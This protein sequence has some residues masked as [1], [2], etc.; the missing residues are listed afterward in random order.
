[1]SALSDRVKDTFPANGDVGV[2]LLSNISVTLSGLDYNTTSLTDGLFVEGP[3]TDQ[4]VGEGLACLLTPENVSQGNIDDFLQSPGYAG[5][6]QGVTT[7][8][9]IAGDTH[10]IFDPT[11]PL[12]PLVEYRLNLT[13][14]TTISG[15]AVDGFVTFAF[16]AGSGSIQELPTEISTSPLAAA[17]PETGTGAVGPFAVTT[18]APLD[19]SVQNPTDMREIVIDFNKSIDPDSVAGNVIVKTVPATDHPNAVTASLGDI[20]VSTEVLGNRLKIKI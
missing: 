14:V 13:S 15:V 4:F 3:D 5:I 17:T 18:A 8:T 1:M 19:H 10:V 7:V 11:L 12:A 9:G 2:P 20:A 16:T 6:A